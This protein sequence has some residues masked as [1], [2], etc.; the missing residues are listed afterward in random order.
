MRFIVLALLLFTTV[1]QA[2][3]GEHWTT[4]AIVADWGTTL[5]IENHANIQESNPLLGKHPSRGTIN[6]YFIAKIA[7]TY[8]LKNKT[9]NRIQF[10]L[11][12]MAVRNNYQLGLKVRF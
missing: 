1:A 11:S 10:G 8:Y 7:A 6:A 3:P 4:A 2:N 5:D 9:W 12:L